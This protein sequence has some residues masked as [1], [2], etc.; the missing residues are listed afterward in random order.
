MALGTGFS[1]MKKT[2][3]C[4]PILN[5]KG[6]KCVSTFWDTLYFLFYFFQIIFFKL[7]FFF[8]I[9][10]S[11]I[12]FSKIFLTIFASSAVALIL[13]DSHQKQRGKTSLQE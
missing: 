2:F 3:V 13:Q 6:L 1:D 7:N 11:T 5:Y 12:F 4:Y 9:I 8:S 10:F